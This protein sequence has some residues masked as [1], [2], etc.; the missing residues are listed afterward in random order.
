MAKIN[1]K[2][3]GIGVLAIFISFV[4]VQSLFFK[5]TGAPETQHIFGILDKWA[6]DQFGIS[7]LFLPP[8]IFNAYVIG[9]AEL[10]ASILLLTGLFTRIKILLPLGGLMSLGVITGAIFF[11][12]FTPLGI[13]VQDDGGALFIMACLVWLSAASLTL[14]H[15]RLIFDLLP[16]KNKEAQA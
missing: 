14:I 16:K 7:G 1:K 10:I 15:R 13:V 4:F 12:V 11:H 8:G 6:T 9:T 3:F 5:F 2:T